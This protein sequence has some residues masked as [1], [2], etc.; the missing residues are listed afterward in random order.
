MHTIFFFKKIYNVLIF[1]KIILN[2]LPP[3]NTNINKYLIKLKTE[4]DY[5]K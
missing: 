5:L 1:E 4:I 2:R 3:I